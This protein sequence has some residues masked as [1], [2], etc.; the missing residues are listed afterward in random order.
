MT[1]TQMNRPDIDI[2]ED[3]R[4]VIAHYPPATADR[5][6]LHIEAHNGNVI[7]SG[8]VRSLITRTYLI[9]HVRAIA[10]VRS[11]NTDQLYC[12]ERIRIESGRPLPMGVIANAIYG[13][14]VLT[15]TLPSGTSAES[16]VKDV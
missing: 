5:H 6:Q 7:L 15:G 3:I 16:V 14:V 8:H 12:E 4:N 11:V 1:M 10:G 2:E 9:D 13:T